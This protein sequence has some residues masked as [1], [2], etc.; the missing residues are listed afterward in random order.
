[1]PA[2]EYHAEDG[3]V[4][5]LKEASN[6]FN[7]LVTDNSPSSFSDLSVKDACTPVCHEVNAGSSVASMPVHLLYSQ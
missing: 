1:M 3:S 6:V 2:G 7:P 4:M 5:K